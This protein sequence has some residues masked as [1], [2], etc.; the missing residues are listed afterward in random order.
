MKAFFGCR[1]VIDWDMP[2]RSVG[3]AGAER[4]KFKKSA[5][6]RRAVG[7]IRVSGR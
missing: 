5:S 2:Q 1:S 6:F 7:T 4:K 3:I